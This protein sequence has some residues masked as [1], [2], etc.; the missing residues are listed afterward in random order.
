MESV[1]FDEPLLIA[2]IAGYCVDRPAMVAIST[3]QGRNQK[4]A[5]RQRAQR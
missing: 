2:T 1:P 3:I 5:V 4:P